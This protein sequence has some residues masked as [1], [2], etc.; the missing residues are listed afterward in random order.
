MPATEIAVTT[1]ATQFAIAVRMMLRHA[2]NREDISADLATMP[3]VGRAQSLFRSKAAVGG[4]TL[5][6]WQSSD[7]K[8][9]ADAFFGSLANVSLIDAAL[10]AGAKRIPQNLHVGL[11]ASGAS[12]STTPEA[13]P[14]AVTRLTTDVRSITATR[15]DALVITS[16]E[17]AQS[18]NGAATSL[19][20]NE[21]RTQVGRASN[22]ALLSMLTSTSATAGADAIANLKA[23]L[24]AADDSRAYVVAATPADTR[25]LALNAEGR[26]GIFGGT[27]IPGVHVVAVDDIAHMTVIPVD[28]LAVVDYGATVEMAGEA[29]VQMTDAPSGAA[30]SVS[31]W[32]TNSVGVLVH[33]LFAARGTCITVQ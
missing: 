18:E 22:T 13:A 32:Q 23:G 12:A 20:A 28:S 11:F 21:L 15:A 7:G 24:A 14:A 19:I 8:V 16:K 25:T 26:M 1:N 5:D 4:E 9:L 10:A 2:G 31:L 30:A 6:A 27:F 17:L 3:C 29:D 33:R